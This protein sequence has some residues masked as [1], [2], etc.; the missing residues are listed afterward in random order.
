MIDSNKVEALKKRL[1]NVVIS[2]LDISA[3]TL[4]IN[5]VGFGTH[6]I[7]VGKMLD[8]TIT[9]ITYSTTEQEFK[10]DVGKWVN[11]DKETV[12]DLPDRSNADTSMFIGDT[13][14]SVGIY[15]S[16][17]KIHGKKRFSISLTTNPNPEAKRGRMKTI[18][19]GIN[20][21]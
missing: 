16:E 18:A 11:D 15:V 7:D 2:S 21:K 19:F 20:F 6:A 8:V 3:S 17:K 14:T 10:K 9:D 1:T 4:K 12:A 13:I 5:P